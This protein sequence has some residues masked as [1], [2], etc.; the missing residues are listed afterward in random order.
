ML[1]V[2]TRV[3]FVDNSYYIPGKGPQP[4]E[5]SYGD[6]L[7]KIGVIE[8]IRKYFDSDVMIYVSFEDGTKIS[9]IHWRVKPIED[10]IGND[11]EYQE[12]FV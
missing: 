1:A 9:M 10:D 6:C 7:G 11:P 3:K 8:R 5:S 4:G 2:G 12:L